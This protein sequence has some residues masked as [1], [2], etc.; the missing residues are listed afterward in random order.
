MNPE[1]RKA[2][3]I[4]REQLKR[5]LHQQQQKE[6]CKDLLTQL[7]AEL[8]TYKIIWTE[9]TFFNP[10]SSWLTENFPIA[11]W[12]RVN[13]EK[14]DGCMQSAVFVTDYEN[15]SQKLQQIILNQNLGNPNVIIVWADANTLSLELSLSLVVQHAQ[16]VCQQSWDT[17]I[18]CPQDN[19]CIEYYHEGEISFGYSPLI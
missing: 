1:R 11:W 5:Q 2:L 13:W 18:I 17:W 14:V 7:D 8:A 3:I 9:P 19:W 12:G 15:F 10:A 6:S 16:L 4:R